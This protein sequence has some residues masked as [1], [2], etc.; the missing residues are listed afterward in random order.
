MDPASSA[1]LPLRRALILVVTAAAVLLSLP[2]IRAVRADE[3]A[4]LDK[5]V[6]V[7]DKTDQEATQPDQPLGEVSKKTGVP[8][9]QLREQKAKTKLNSG[10]LYIANTL[11]AFQDQRR[12][13]NC[14]PVADAAALAEVSPHSHP[15]SF[16]FLHGADWKELRWRGSYFGRPKR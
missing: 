12:S 16:P 4:D 9:R 13:S 15:P 10:G 6:E 14:A 5:Q 1:D 3:A 8:E 11:A 2:G 7:I